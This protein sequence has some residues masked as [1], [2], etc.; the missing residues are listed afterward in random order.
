MLT[1][2]PGALSLADLR[3]IHEGDAP[4]IALDPAAIPSIN[5]GAAAVARIAASGVPAYGINTGFGRLAQTHIPQ[6]QLELLQ[7]NLVLSHAVGVG[8]PM[9]PNVVRLLLVLKISSLGHGYSGIRLELVDALIKLYNADLLPVIPEK[10]SVGASGDLAPLAHMAAVLLGVGEVMHAGA[11]MSAT[12]ALAKLGMAPMTL[13]PKEGL[14]LLNGT[15]ASTALA[16]A[17]L[18]DTEELFKTA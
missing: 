18:F 4:T 3:K 7:R 12:E 5:A 6:D 9:A 13:A 17:N 11:R 16:L 2:T 15:Q 1:I 8:K 14:A 10:G